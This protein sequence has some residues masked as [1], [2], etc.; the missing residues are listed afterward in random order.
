MLTLVDHW[1][2]V[3]TCVQH[4]HPSFQAS[5]TSSSPSPSSTSSLSSIVVSTALWLSDRA[6]HLM[7]LSE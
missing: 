3:E 5:G 1:Q 4:E 7:I 2:M 6:T